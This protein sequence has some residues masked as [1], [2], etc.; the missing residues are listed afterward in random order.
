MIRICLNMI[1]KDEAHVIRR[2]I[3]SV[4]PL[5]DSWVI[6][7]TGSTDG[8]QDVIREALADLPG[9]LHE[10]PW[11]DF[12]H[13][14]SEAIELARG[15][16]GYLLFID[17]DDTLEFEPEFTR[18]EG[19][20]DAYEIQI[21]H[22]ELRYGRLCLVDNSLPW[23]FVGVLHE[24]PDCGR[25]VVRKPLRGVRLNFLG[26]GGR[27]QVSVVEKY[28]RDAKILEAAVEREPDNARYRFYLAQSY[29]DSDQPERALQAYEHR[30]TMGGFAEEVF[31]SLLRAARLARALGHGRDEV[32]ARYL[33][34]HEARPTRAEALGQLAQYLREHGP[35]WELAYLFA[36]RAVEIPMPTSDVLFVEPEWYDWRCLDEFA[37]AA[38]WIGRRDESR[39]ACEKLLA[40][41][42]LPA[43]QVDRVRANLRFSLEAVT[44]SSE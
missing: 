32:I 43:S 37:V 29:R 40:S 25:P 44:I 30:A 12:G 24:Y 6:V 22:G 33:R 42:K 3:D 38:Y 9:E 11:R 27:S 7:D 39:A 16:G 19:D 15:H 10:R 31:C 23:R 18:P 14:R 20:A 21:H 34:A 41:Q 17:A 26:G 8:T 36:R 28:A 1:V 4:R 2:C 5:I 35:C 13:N